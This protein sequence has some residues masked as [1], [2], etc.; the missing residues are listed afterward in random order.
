MHSD[1]VQ[2]FYQRMKQ[3][4]EYEVKIPNPGVRLLL[5]IWNK[6]RENKAGSF[7]RWEVFI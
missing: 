4:S 1:L 6:E 2:L 3:E 7:F 5:P